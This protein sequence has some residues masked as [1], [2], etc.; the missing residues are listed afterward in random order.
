MN[1][2]MNY[3][4]ILSAS[5]AELRKSAGMTQ[6]ALAEKLGVTFQAVSK[7]ENGLAM[8]DITFLPRLSEIF[9]VTVDSLFG[10]AAR[11]SP[12]RKTFPQ[13]SASSTGTTTACCAAVLFV[14]NRITDRQELT[15]TKFKFTFE[16]DGTVRDV[17]S[18]FS[19]SCGDV[20][21]NVT[22]EV[23]NIN[24]SDIDGDVSTESGNINCSDIDGD[25]S[26]ES[27]SINC[28][29]IDGDVSTESGSISCGDIDGDATT[30]SGS[31]SC[32]DI[33]GDATTASGSIS[34]GDI[35]GDATIGDCK[36]DA[37]ISCADVGG[38]VIIKG[39]GSV[40]VT[41]DIEGN[42]TATT[43]IRE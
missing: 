17:I 13:R 26:T 11:Q 29:D 9:G 16:Y 10:L 5:I 4:A 2:D 28:C 3:G 34:C 31:I 41:G 30:E 42:V 18:D 39:D 15:E 36:G 14:G 24:C 33:G 37:K 27:G 22:T 23:G 8:P 32:G 12:K 21:G 40:T 38:D 19:V 1:Q 25:V 43:V 7:W 6:D 35:G 20:E